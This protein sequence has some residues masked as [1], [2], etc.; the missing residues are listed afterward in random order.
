MVF[1]RPVSVLVV[2]IACV[3]GSTAANAEDPSW[4][5]SINGNAENT[6]NNLID[7]PIV[8][9]VAGPVNGTAGGLSVSDGFCYD[10]QPRSYTTRY[11]VRESNAHKGMDFSTVTPASLSGSYAYL[12]TS[13]QLVPLLSPAGG[14]VTQA[15]CSAAGWVFEVRGGYGIEFGLW[16][17]YG[18]PL[19]AQG[20]SILAGRRV[21]Y[22]GG[23][24]GGSN[25][26]QVIYSPPH[27]H[28]E[29]QL[30]PGGPD[31][32]PNPTNIDPWVSLRTAYARP[33]LWPGGSVDTA[34]RDLW[35]WVATANGVSDVGYPSV[36]EA[37]GSNVRW[38]VP[39]S[40]LN[41]IAAVQY[42]SVGY[43]TWDGA[44]ARSGALVH[45][46]NAPS[47]FWVRNTFFKK[48]LTLGEQ[49]SFL[50]FPISNDDGVRQNFQGGCVKIV[51]GTTYAA[52]YG[53]W[54]CA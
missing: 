15:R 35:I 48:W 1:R 51:S 42:L 20:S 23:S 21:G 29:M 12:Y 37:I 34:M 13:Q 9:P 49:N 14:L 39:S 16:H 43:S 10:G 53:S 17:L 44:Y 4:P 47:A 6:A 26:S 32:S 22:V 30:P 2:L 18:S 46:L 25:C 52:G 24:G 19:Y 33:G 3:S 8:F 7:F 54:P 38:A 5:T 31:D 11:C 27:L 45:L 50:G 40:N 41:N 36:D 28:F